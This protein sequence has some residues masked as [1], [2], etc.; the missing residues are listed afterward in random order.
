MSIQPLLERWQPQYHT[1]QQLK[2]VRAIYN[3]ES[4]T[5]QGYSMPQI[6]QA[7]KMLVKEHLRSFD[8]PAL[9]RYWEQLWK[10]GRTFEDTMAAVAFWTEPKHYPLA[11]K[12]RDKL[13]DWAGDLTNW[14]HSDGLSSIYA[15][16]LEDAGKPVDHRLLDWNRSDNPWLR[17][18]SVVSLLFYTRHRRKLPAIGRVLGAVEPLLGDAHYYVQKGVGW[19]IR[20]A[21]QVDEKTT[22][23]FIERH[24]LTIQPP[25]YTA[26]VEKLAPADKLR[27]RQLRAEHRRSLKD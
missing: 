25:A 7:V 5:M 3:C 18:Q 14:A 15:R 23:Q 12:H 16:F 17:R 21:Y 22:M 4:L 6:R 9:W 1:P 26:A 20:E 2:M 27:L 11:L 8:E 19:T 13:M 10:H 24:L